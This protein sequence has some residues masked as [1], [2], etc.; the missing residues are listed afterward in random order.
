SSAC[1]CERSSDVSLS[2]L[3]HLMNSRELAVKVGGA[4]AAKEFDK[5]KPPPKGKAAPNAGNKLK[6]TPGERVA[7]LVA[8][9]RPHEEKIREL[10][11]VAFSREPRP[12]ELRLL[13]AHV[14]RHRGNSRVAYE[15]IVWALVNS[16]EFMFNH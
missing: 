5:A 3:L 15:D 1:E 2:Q 13:L 9:K 10:S 12:E 8:D 4:A 16:N 7:Q 11:L 6:I 14:E